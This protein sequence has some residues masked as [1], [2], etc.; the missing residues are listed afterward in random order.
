M[1]SSSSEYDTNKQTN[2]E[3][4]LFQQDSNNNLTEQEKI[5]AKK[6]YNFNEAEIEDGTSK[7]KN[8]SNSKSNGNFFSTHYKTVKKYAELIGENLYFNFFM[9]V[10]TLWTLYQEDIR[11]AVVPKSG[12]T[13]FTIIASIIFFLYIFEIIVLLIYKDDYFNFT[14]S[15]NNKDDDFF[16]YVQSF[17]LIGSFYFWAD[18]LSTAILIFD[19]RFLF[20]YTFLSLKLI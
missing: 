17:F 13:A 10:I 4:V 20:L 1:V 8:I 3:Q 9:V 18:V 6:K 2:N 19:V 14:S 12:D 16:K 15:E 7:E 5:Q 11:L